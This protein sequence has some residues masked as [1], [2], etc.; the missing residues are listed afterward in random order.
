MTSKSSAGFTAS[1]RRANTSGTLRLVPSARPMEASEASRARRMRSRCTRTRLS[2]TGPR[3]SATSRASAR[4][5]AVYTAGVRL[6]AVI[7]PM[8]RPPLRSGTLSPARNPASHT[9]C[10]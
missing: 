7:T 4:W 2:T 1:A 10:S 9:A 5:S 8:M 3:R 6:I